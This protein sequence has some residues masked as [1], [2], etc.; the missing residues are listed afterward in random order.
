MK[1]CRDSPPTET[2]NPS[3]GP[4]SWRR[5]TGRGEQTKSL[6]H[7]QK[8]R[9]RCPAVPVVPLFSNS[10]LCP[11]WT[12]L[13]EQLT[14]PIAEV[15][16]QSVG[17]ALRRC[18]LT[19][20]P[21]MGDAVDVKLETRSPFENGRKGTGKKKVQ[22]PFLPSRSVGFM[23]SVVFARTRSAVSAAQSAFY[24]PRDHIP[25]VV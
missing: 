22:S 2:W 21:T 25:V 23:Y 6:K 9:H 15:E 18:D 8:H 16:D 19:P 17:C 10:Q 11:G 12:G 20:G 5:I 1:R 4:A 3:H 24:E 14:A 13:T 7:G